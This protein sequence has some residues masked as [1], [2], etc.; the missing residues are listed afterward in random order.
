MDKES[1]EK[2]V[3]TNRLEA[4]GLL[5]LDKEDLEAI[6]QRKHFMDYKEYKRRSRLLS[7]RKNN[8]TKRTKKLVFRPLKTFQDFLNHIFKNK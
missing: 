3:F 5:E 2:E 1:F 6:K 4:S 7:G 8:V